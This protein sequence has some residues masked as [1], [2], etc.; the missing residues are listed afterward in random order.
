MRWCL[1]VVLW[2][3]CAVASAGEAFL[4]PVLKTKPE[5]PRALYLAGIE[6][7]VKVSMIVHADGAVSGVSASKGAHPELVEAS[8][9]AVRQW[10][11]KPWEVSSERPAKVEVIA[12]L[13]FR[14]GQNPI[15]HANEALKRIRCSDLTRVAQHYAES[16]WASL[17]FFRWTRSYMTNSIPVTQLPVERR[18]A[19]IAKL[20]KEVPVIIRRCNVQPSSR[21]VRFFPKEVRELL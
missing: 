9:A 21:V 7:D 18:L 3:I 5:Y 15:P 2:S 4:I 19:L 14:L 1:A 17:S 6:G 11:F 13:V 20:N 12:P 16:S 10:K 8:L